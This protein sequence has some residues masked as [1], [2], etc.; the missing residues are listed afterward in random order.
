[1][2]LKLSQFTQLGSEK[3][4]NSEKHILFV[5]SEQNT[6]DF[7]YSEIV[8]AKLKRANGEF[9]DLNKTPMTLDLP[10]GG[11]ASFV[12]L[13][14]QLSTF[15]RHALL[16]K[17]TE[18][19]REEQPSNIS[20]CIF[21]DEATNDVVT[22]LNGM[23]IEI[24]HTDAEGRMVLADTLTLASRADNN[25]KRPDAMI[26]FATLTGSM[27]TALGDRISGVI[28]NQADLANKAVNAGAKA[29]ERIVAFPYDEDYESDL[30]SKIA[31]IKQC[32]LSDNPDHIHA[33]RFLGRFVEGDVAWLH[34]DL[35]S[36]N[37][38]GGLGAVASNTTGFGVGFGLEMIQCLI[39]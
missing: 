21:G 20:I 25:G 14:N 29:G 27:M 32:S 11:M 16:C 3:T 2:S 24:V 13:A 31:D 8:H 39:K 17:A 7:P 23:T 28:A 6:N 22:A 36:A 33:A 15:Q 30:D 12:I 1:M 4:L 26:D 35:S 10:N 18:A 34:T 38:E 19:F 37:R 9:K 5:L